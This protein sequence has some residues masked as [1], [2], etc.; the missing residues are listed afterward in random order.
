MVVFTQIV[1]AG[2]LA[3]REWLE[4]DGGYDIFLRRITKG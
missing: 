1:K 2:G 3:L 4:A